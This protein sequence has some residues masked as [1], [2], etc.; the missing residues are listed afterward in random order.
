MAEGASGDRAPAGLLEQLTRSSLDEDYA[1]VA[2]RRTGSPADAEASHRRRRAS[3]LVAVLAGLGLLLATAAVHTAQT[4]AERA[5][6]RESLV[7]QVAAHRADVAR[8]RAEVAR[9]RSSVQ[10]LERELLRTSEAARTQRAAV[11]RL[12]VA[13]GVEAVTGPGVRVVVD[14][15]PG[16]TT[17]REVV[18]DE[19]LQRL[20][21]GLWVAG[22][23]AVAVNDQRLTNLTAIREAGSAITVNFTSLRRPYVGEAVGDP[24]QLPARFIE[25]DGGSWWLNLRSVYGLQF[26]V[27]SEESLTVP[28]VPLPRLRHVTRTGAGS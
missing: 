21:N 25:S 24:E 6:S 7:T 8:A 19:D 12:G 10:Q 13:A 27:T 2:A 28:A 9:L 15:R 18:L 4:S 26:T 11:R 16:A 1:A 22:A 20:V 3:A 17:D 23:E 14:D 5:S